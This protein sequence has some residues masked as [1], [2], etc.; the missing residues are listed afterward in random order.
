MLQRAPPAQ[1]PPLAISDHAPLD[2][3]LP[4]HPVTVTVLD[5]SDPPVKGVAPPG[6][7]AAARRRQPLRRR[8]PC[9]RERER[10]AGRLPEGCEYRLPTEAE[11][12][13]AARGGTQS[14]GYAYA[15]SND[16]D[17]VAWHVGNS[18]GATHPVGSKR[19]N[20]LGLCDMSGNT[21]EWCL[22]GFDGAYYARSPADDP[23]NAP[24]DA[25]RVARGGSW[26]HG[27]EF[28][29]VHCRVYQVADGPND[30]IGFRIA[31]APA[32]PSPAR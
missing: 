11:W 29:G 6:P 3:A 20:E 18:R 5:E 28:A 27:A 10:G 24:V 25:N 17:E 31:L 4:V 9:G 26:T 2:F 8:R 15:G 16:L 14:H 12:E 22:D 21:N 13:Y 19:P 7:R 30:N 23:I 32:P 1:A